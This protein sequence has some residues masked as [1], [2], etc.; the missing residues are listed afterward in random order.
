MNSVFLVWHTHRLSADDE[1]E[2]LIGVYRTHANAEAAINRL[3]D[4]P[5]F[6]DTPEGFEI[7]ECVLDR[8][9]WTEGYISVAE[10]M[11]DIEP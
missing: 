4:K 9:G 3:K 1:D 2:K 11:K 7:A 10:A 6:R 8:D 5:G